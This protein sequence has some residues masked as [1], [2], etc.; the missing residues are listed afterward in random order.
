LHHLN[1]NFIN[2]FLSN[3]LSLLLIDDR[4]EVAQSVKKMLTTSSVVPISERRSSVIS[5]FDGMYQGYFFTTA[6]SANVG[7]AHI[8]TIDGKKRQ[9]ATFETKRFVFEVLLRFV[10]QDNGDYVIAGYGHD[11]AGTIFIML[12]VSYI[13]AHTH[14]HTLTK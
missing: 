1:S 2:T 6:N 3:N 10:L 13:C 7:G 12:F 14:T 8:H 4:T 5:T 11:D 9:S